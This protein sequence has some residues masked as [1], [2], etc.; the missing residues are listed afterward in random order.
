MPEGLS[1]ASALGIAQDAQGFVWIA[2]Q[3]GLDRYDGYGFRIYQHD[4][5]DTHSLVAN[6]LRR[7]LLDRQGAPPGPAPPTAALAL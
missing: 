2:T 7:L 1:Q 5:G 3:D 4:R 6:N